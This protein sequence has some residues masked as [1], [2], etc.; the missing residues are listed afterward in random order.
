LIFTCLIR[1]S[2]GSCMSSLISA[3]DYLGFSY[4]TCTVSSPIVSVCHHFSCLLC[5]AFCLPIVENRRRW[6]LL[7]YGF[8]SVVDCQGENEGEER[9]VNQGKFVLLQ[10]S[11]KLQPFCSVSVSPYASRSIAFW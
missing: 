1:R 2:D 10:V 4:K 7:S 5:A 11:P 3:I 8:I 9:K 6:L